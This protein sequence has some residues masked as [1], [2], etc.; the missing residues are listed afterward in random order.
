MEICADP[1][2]LPSFTIDRS[3]ATLTRQAAAA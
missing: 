3:G 2:D 1:K